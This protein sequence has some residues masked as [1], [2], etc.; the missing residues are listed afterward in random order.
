MEHLSF[1]T[2]NALPLFQGIGRS[3]LEKFKETVPHGIKTFEP[4]AV[5]AAQDSPCEI[6]F[7]PFR[8]T[9]KVVCASD[10]KRFS[11][12]EDLQAP[13]AIEPE[14]LYGIAP[15]FKRT[16]IA[17]DPVEAIVLPKDSVTT[18]FRESE[19]FRLNML[20]ILSTRIYRQQKGLWNAASGDIRSRIVHFI[21]VHA[22]YP[23]GEKI[24]NV[25]MACLAEQLND[26][27]ANISKALHQLEAE[28]FVTLRN[29]KIRVSALEQLIGYV[30]TQKI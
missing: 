30:Q 20:N 3:Q 12:Q 28:G 22:L 2:F 19:I 6:L 29:K 15:R 17:A 24:L 18:L 5:L 21:L 25:S 27:R 4:D 11:L 10:N 23:A 13:T 1:E 26:T 16:Y 14:G 7:I 9:L 8:G